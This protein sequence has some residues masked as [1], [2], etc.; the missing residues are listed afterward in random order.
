MFERVQTS[1]F[2][3]EHSAK[4]VEKF[5][6]YSLYSLYVWLIIIINDPNISCRQH[7]QNFPKYN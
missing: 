4:V 7:V 5:L 2:V 3:I 6:L 1:R